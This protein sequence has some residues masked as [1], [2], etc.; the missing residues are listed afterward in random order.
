MRNQLRAKLA[1]LL[2]ETK[3]TVSAEQAAVS[4]GV[5]PREAAKTLARWARQGRLSRVRR[6]LYVPVP[7][8]AG[9]GDVALEEPWIIAERLFNPC[10]VGGWNAAEHWGLT[11]QIF[12][13]VLVM[14]TKKPRKRKL[15]IKGTTF[16]LRTI[17]SDSFFGTKPVWRGQVKVNVSDPTRTVLDI[18]D[19]PALGGGAR[20]MTDVL[21]NYLGSKSKD[22]P[23][24]IS[25]A[26][27]L[28]HGAVFKRL[29]FLLERFAPAER[30]ALA[31]CR[32]R[33]TTGNVKLDPTLPAERLAT[34]WRLWVPANW[35]KEQTG[36]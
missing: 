26:D 10:Y 29:G 15:V 24:L 5:T 32:S 16:V 6:G 13:S 27:R 3:G 14:T 7:L 4:L 12:R 31:A 22:L 25:Y 19:D 18:L 11:E 17:Q 1:K 33:L 8:E 23:L 35:M 21:R 9:T 28:G 2:R 20:P 36:D 34:S 30:E